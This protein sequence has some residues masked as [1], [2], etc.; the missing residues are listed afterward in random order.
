MSSFGGCPEPGDTTHM[1]ARLLAGSTLYVSIFPSGDHD[2]GNKG[3][4]GLAFTSSSAVPLPSARCQK[5]PESPP[6]VEKKT[7]RSPV[8]VQTGRPVLP[9]N[10]DSR[11]DEAPVSSEIHY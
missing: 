4:P 5:R 7:I 2:S 6:R 10:G 1:A 9:P 8:G 11:S 3:T